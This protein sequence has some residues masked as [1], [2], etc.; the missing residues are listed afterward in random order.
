V[1][2]PYDRRA[3]K[4]VGTLLHLQIVIPATLAPIAVSD[5]LPKF[6]IAK[7]CHL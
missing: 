4:K 5:T 3:F 1:D 6:D 2:S 7:E